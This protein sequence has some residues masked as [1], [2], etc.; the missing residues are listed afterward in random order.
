VKHDSS[1]KQTSHTGGGAVKKPQSAFAIF[2]QE[3][4][5]S[6]KQ[7][8]Q[9]QAGGGNF[10]PTMFLSEASKKWNAMAPERK[11]KYLDIA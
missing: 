1:V 5:E 4:K 11:Q 7:E 2:M 8:L 6:L 9:A 10:K 3:N